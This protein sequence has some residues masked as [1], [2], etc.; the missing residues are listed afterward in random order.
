MGAGH[1][2]VCEETFEKFGLFFSNSAKSGGFWVFFLL[3]F[4]FRL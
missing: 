4:A 1:L 2:M 3:A